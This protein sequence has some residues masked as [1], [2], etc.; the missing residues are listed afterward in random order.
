MV[1]ASRKA[2]GAHLCRRRN[3]GVMT[4][5]SLS[6]EDFQDLLDRLGGDTNAWPHPIRDY[7]ENL[8]AQSLEARTLLAEACAVHAGL[9]ETVKAPSGLAD[10]IIKTALNGDKGGH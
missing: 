5:S 4:A 9:K 2:R 6:I 1:L 7:A 8:L 3:R 10:R